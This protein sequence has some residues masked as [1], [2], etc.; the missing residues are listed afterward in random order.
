AKPDEWKR[1]QFAVPAASQVDGVRLRLRAY[2]R[3][4]DRSTQFFVDKLTIEEAPTWV[5]L[6]TPVAHL[7][8]I[9]LNWTESGDES[10]FRK[11]EIYRRE[12]TGVTLSDTRVAQITDR[13]QTAF[14]DTGLSI[15]KTYYY[16]VYVY[17]LNDT[18]T[19]SN[20]GQATTVPVDPPI[21]DS[22]NDLALWD[23]RGS[24]GIETN[25]TGSWLSDSPYSP[26]GNNQR[27]T[28]NYA[29]T[30]V[31]LSDAVWPVLSF[32]DRFSFSGTDRAW[33]QISKDGVN[34]SARYVCTGERTDWALQQLDLSEWAGE[35]NVR[36]RFYLYTDSTATADG[37]QLDDLSVA[38][39][40]SA[41][42]SLPVYE[43]F[44]DRGT[45]WLSGGW[46]VSSNESYEGAASAQSLPIGFTPGNTDIYASYGKELNLSGSISP[47]LTL[48]AKG[49]DDSYSHLYAQLSKDGG[50]TWTDLSGD[51]DAKPDEWKRFQFAVPAA[52]QVDGVR[53]RLRAY[54]R[55]YDRS[56]QFF[57]DRLTIGE[58][59]PSAP[60]PI[61]PTDDSIV[62]VLYPTLTVEN[63]VDIVDDNCSYEFEIYTNAALSVDSL[64]SRLPVLASGDGT[65]SWQVDVEMV[66][67]QQYWWRSRA[68]SSSD[69]VSD[70]SVTS[71]YH[72]V[73]VNTAPSAPGIL[74]PYSGSTLPDEKGLFIWSGSL[75]A[76]A[77]DYVL[78]Y[79]LEI[80]AENQFTN[81]L[82][83]AV[84]ATDESIGTMRLNE[85]SGYESLPLDESYFWRIRAVDSHGLGSEWTSESFVYGSVTVPVVID[86]VTITSLAI[87]GSEVRIEWTKTEFPVD[88][89]FSET[90]MPAQWQVLDGAQNLSTNSAVLACPSDARG[91]FRL[92]I[93]R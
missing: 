2:T 52:S 50:K 87:T 73:I 14:T 68:T 79:R 55:T 67:G 49:I 58:V 5:T 32:W 40:E 65:T 10:T 31:D 8:S 64:V 88:V 41:A 75:D 27:E 74:S 33:L 84:K 35:P 60:V 16:K 80:A 91:F 43:R 56:T 93:G 30:A 71:T 92:I 19:P 81:V 1:F 72:V 89:E 62:D 28:D 66:D 15:G 54:T 77:G 78:E 45:N 76:D 90:L 61:S 44:E 53:L 23:T 70:W 17:N 7:K 4:Y 26:Y 63:A 20:E 86:P 82:L 48:W 38:E 3:T 36:I 83:S 11:Y 29:L 13:T 24:W 69:Q 22:L 46:V 12:S 34:W 18:A 25:A 42:Q 6:D 37:W 9:D 59:V 47:Q 85:I 39:H 21:D 57:V 51:M